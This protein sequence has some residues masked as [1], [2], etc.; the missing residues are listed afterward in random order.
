MSASTLIEMI[1]HFVVSFTRGVTEH[2]NPEEPEFTAESIG[3]NP[4][5][6][7][8]REWYCH[9]VDE[10][11]YQEYSDKEATRRDYLTSGRSVDIRLTDACSLENEEADEDEPQVDEDGAMAWK[12]LRPSLFLSVCKSMYFG[13]FISLLTA[14]VVGTVYMLISYLSY[15]TVH[16]C[17]FQSGNLI[18]TR[19]QWMRTIVSIVHCLF[20]YIWYLGNAL[21]L[22]RPFQLM[23]VKRRLILVSCLTYCS[24]T[25]YRVALQALGL[26]NSKMSTLKKI[27]LNIIFLISVCWQVYF[28]TSHFGMRARSR[29]QK[30]FFFLQMTIPNCFCFLLALTMVT[31]IYPS[32]NKQNKEGKLQIALFVPLIGVVLKVISRIC[33]Q[34]LWNT[35]HPGRSYVLLVPL[36]CGSAV[37]FR[38]LQADLDSLQSIAILGII[39]GAAE[40]ME[41]S[42]MVVIDHICHTLWKGRSAPWGRFRTPRRERLMADITIMSM[43]FESTAVVSVN[44]FLYSYRFIYLQNDS[45]LKLL[46]SFAIHTSV[47][48]VIEWFFTS[49]SLVI[50]TRYQNMAV[51]AVWRKQWKRHVVVAIVNVVPIAIWTTTNL[52]LIVHGR[53]HEANQ[54][55]KMP[56]T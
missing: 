29:K 20:I 38:V 53:F 56:F 26:S 13:A 44:G 55:C 33:A 30:L 5:E 50:A 6:S 9:P 48:L 24:D 11:I 18:P 12:R 8:E 17:E 15:K 47:P 45:L 42:T 19:V 2:Y 51:M 10:L 3:Y 39:H 36:Y 52:L 22:F 43:L 7:T 37:M 4:L 49:V 1:G 25:L 54:P 23:G 40:V 31:F 28:L 41:R 32:Y 14:S 35:T 34:R 16:N 46:S 27:P 21:F